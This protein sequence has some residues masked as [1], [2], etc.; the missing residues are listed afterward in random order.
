MSGPRYTVEPKVQA[1]LANHAEDHLPPAYRPRLLHLS[2]DLVPG[3]DLFITSRTV[4]GLAGPAEPNV[5]PHTHD[6]SQTYIFLSDDGS[7]EV[8]IEIE[9]ERTTAR[10]PCTTF[11]PAGKLHSLRIL[12]GT[13][14][15]V[16]V[17]RAGEYA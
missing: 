6:V 14:T 1:T 8:E 15:V 11:I 2:A 12:R 5:K 9:G 10:A 3:A 13:G 16:S 7:L 17:V 4:D